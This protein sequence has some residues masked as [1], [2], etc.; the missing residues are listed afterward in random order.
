MILKKN[1]KIM[2]KYFKL[3][4]I[5]RKYIALLPA[6]KVYLKNLIKPIWKKSFF[7]ICSK[8]KNEDEKIFAEE[9]SIEILKNLGLIENI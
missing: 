9:D 2:L 7:I 4:K 5:W 6:S 1:C 8:R 3:L